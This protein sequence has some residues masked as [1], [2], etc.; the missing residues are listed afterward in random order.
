MDRDKLYAIVDVIL[1]LI[2]AITIFAWLYVA[3]A[4]LT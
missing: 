3:L 2:A 4:V 1:S